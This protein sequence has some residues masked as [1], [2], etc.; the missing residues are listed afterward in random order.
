MSEE[1]ELVQRRAE[2]LA[3]VVLTRRLNVDVLPLEEK[4]E[5]GIDFIAAI[6]D[7][8]VKGFLR[9][10]M[11]ID[12]LGRCTTKHRFKVKRQARSLP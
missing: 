5:K 12:A 1:Q 7:E 11:R 9:L 8:R 4:Y 10:R 2:L 6:R 3:R